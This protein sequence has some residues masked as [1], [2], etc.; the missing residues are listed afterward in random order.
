ML[1]GSA[2]YGLHDTVRDKTL[3]E[4]N[5]LQ[6]LSGISLKKKKK[7]QFHCVLTFFFTFLVITYKRE[8]LEA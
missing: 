1:A 8:F 2:A 4:G 7:V 3:Q 6:L 5:D